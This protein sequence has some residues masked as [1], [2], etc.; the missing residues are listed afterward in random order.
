MPKSTQPG[1]Y[2]SFKDLSYTVTYRGR[3]IQ[4]LNKVTGFARP[5]MVRMFFAELFYAIRPFRSQMLALMGSSGAGKTTLLDVLAERKTAG[6]VSGEILVNG[7][8]PNKYF[9]RIVGYV[10][11]F[12]LHVMTQ[13]VREAFE[14]SAQVQSG[15][16]L[17][18]RLPSLT[19]G[20]VK[21]CRLP[22]EIANSQK[23]MYVVKTLRQVGLESISHYP[24]L[25]L[26][27]EQLKRVTIGVELVADPGLVF[28]DEPTSGLDAVAADKIMKVVQ[29][30]C[31]EE[32]RT[33]ICTIHQ[34][35]VRVFKLFTH[36]M[37]LKKGG[38]VVYFGPI[39]ENYS[40]L[41]RYFEH[42]QAQGCPSN[43]VR[44]KRRR[45]LYFVA[46]AL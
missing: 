36:L 31:L 44:P 21:Q 23:E 13:T 35:S 2:L 37:L 3:K 40:E 20:L 30:I 19:C 26:S 29:Q 8:P 34:P 1:T 33:I 24:L 12:N 41:F 27:P 32:G 7:E 46:T 6:V 14:F 45:F 22:R 17:V 25:E 18:P 42:S 9:H 4:L 15:G 11:Q 43:K 28:L 16:T 39:G 38:H 10:E 5:G